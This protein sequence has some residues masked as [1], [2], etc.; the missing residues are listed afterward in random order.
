MLPPNGLANVWQPRSSV[1]GIVPITC[2][3]LELLAMPMVW[4]VVPPERRMLLPLSVKLGAPAW[5]ARLVNAVP[6][7]RSLVSVVGVLGPNSSKSP[8]TGGALPPVQLP[9][10]LQ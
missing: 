4:V 10:V 1:R 3:A 9:G 5:K 2:A 8:A 6:A 7:I